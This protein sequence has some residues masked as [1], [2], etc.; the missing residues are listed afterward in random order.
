MNSK[1]FSI[2]AVFTIICMFFLSIS[3]F[4]QDMPQLEA[5]TSENLEDR[6]DEKITELNGVVVTAQKREQNIQDV[7]ASVT[8][9]SL[10]DIE[11]AGIKSTTDIDSYV[12][13]LTSFGLSSGGMGFSYYGMRGQTNFNSYS[14]SI[15]IYIDDVP[16][17]LSGNMTNSSLWEVEQIEVLRGPQGNLYGMSASG[18]IINI[19]TRKP[20]NE[21]TGKAGVLLGNYNRREYQAYISGPVI[22][23]ILLFSFSGTRKSQDCYVEEDGNND[24]ESEFTGGRFQL[25]WMP[26][27]KLDI[28]FSAE[29]GEQDREYTWFT[30]MDDDPYTIPNLNYPEYDKS[31]YRILSLKITYQT[32]AFDIISITGNTDLDQE[33]DMKMLSAGE[34]SRFSDIPTSKTIQE[35]RL[36]SNDEQSAFK[37]MLGGFYQD[38]TQED[39]MVTAYNGMTMTDLDGEVQKKTYS[40]FGQASYTF[41]D[42][43]TV[44]GGLRYDYEE[45][46]YTE[47]TEGLSTSTMMPYTMDYDMSDTWDSLSPRV[48]VDYRIQDEIMVYASMAKGYKAGGFVSNDAVDKK[49]DQEEVLSYELGMKTN[50]LNNRLIFNLCGFYTTADDLQTFYYD[51][52]YQFRYENTAEAVMYGFETELIFKPLEG[53]EISLPVGYVHSEIKEHEIES[54]V[55]NKVPMTPEYTVGFSTRYTHDNGIF[56]RGE[57]N[58]VGQTFYDEE[59]EHGQ[60]AYGLVNFKLGY[61]AEHFTVSAFI[62]NAFDEEYYSFI[63]DTSDM[64]LAYDYASVGAP[65][66]IGAEVSFMF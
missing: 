19:T 54:L 40:M 66:T 6:K 58:V 28:L 62:N 51:A 63:Y 38:G 15:G 60:D 46:D 10:K 52:G 42:K 29:I 1:K 7:P 26:S 8:A 20:E 16:R 41:A 31:D 39:G 44:T 34:M 17:L 56:L 24:R 45:Q 22:E 9:F 65:Q 13:N 14:N 47:H 64:G 48:S 49:Y 53:L 33:V 37:W 30:L 18:G 55:G 32:S 61:I 27:D 57:Y 3:V 43:L 23:D 50:W 5:N 11:D 25:N 2:F 21:L 59:N 35:L 12:P 4:A 36:V